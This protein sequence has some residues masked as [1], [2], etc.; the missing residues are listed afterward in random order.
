[1]AVRLISS[2]KKNYLISK[3]KNERHE[4]SE[5]SY[6]TLFE[7][8]CKAIVKSEALDFVFCEITDK[9]S[10]RKP[11]MIKSIYNKRKN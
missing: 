9:H 4:E 8:L 2:L 7:R 3:I 1:M 6:F 10:V 5:I 11:Y